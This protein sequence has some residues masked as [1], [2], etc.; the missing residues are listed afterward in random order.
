MK[1]NTTNE[2]CNFK[3][4]ETHVDTVEIINDSFCITLDN[5]I[6]LSENSANRDVRNMRANNILFKICNFSI[7]KIVKEGYK[8]Y[9][10][11]GKLL[12]QYEDWVVEESTYNDL[13]K[14]F[15]DSWLYSMEKKNDIYEI[16][17]DANEHTYLLTIKGSSD[18]QHWDRF[19][20]L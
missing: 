9:D 3:F 8:I 13:F 19:L 5:V 1:Y 17:I 10:A 18:E 4:E 15:N 16:V 11:D 6:I 2:L 12:N 7:E 20:N 14:S